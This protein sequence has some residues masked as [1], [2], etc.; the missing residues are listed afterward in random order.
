MDA[1][2]ARWHGIVT[3][4]ASPLLSRALRPARSM[5]TWF[6]RPSRPA[7]SRSTR[8][9]MPTPGRVITPR[10]GGRGRCRPIIRVFGTRRFLMQ[11]PAK[12][13]RLENI[14]LF[15]TGC[16]CPM[17]RTTPAPHASRSVDSAAS[18]RGTPAGSPNQRLRYPARARYVHPRRSK[19]AV[20][21][22]PPFLRSLTALIAS[23]GSLGVV[24]G[25][26]RLFA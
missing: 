24:P 25:F 7:P 4:S 16:S 6:G 11:T 18:F 5:R 20:W 1:G 26:E 14:I 3:S 13:L 8:N 19:Q 21:E 2:S 9:A 15:A 10:G 22:G 12:I 17:A 23:F